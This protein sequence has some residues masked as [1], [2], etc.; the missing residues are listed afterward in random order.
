MNKWNYIGV[1]TKPTTSLATK[2]LRDH[3]GQPLIGE[4]DFRV[5]GDSL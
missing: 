4:Q 2:I 3:L 5:Y 1:S